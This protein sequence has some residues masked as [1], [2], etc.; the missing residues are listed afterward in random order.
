MILS[1]VVTAN[2]FSDK[3]VTANALI[4]WSISI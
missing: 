2:K 3:A 4:Y 1:L